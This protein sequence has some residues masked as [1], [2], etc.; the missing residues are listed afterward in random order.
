MMPEILKQKQTLRKSELKSYPILLF[1]NIEDPRYLFDSRQDISFQ[2]FAESVAFETEKNCYKYRQ[3]S[4]Y[5]SV[6]LQ[7]P[8]RLSQK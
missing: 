6:K 5:S 8:A 2:P 4:P 1:D 7:G 3:I